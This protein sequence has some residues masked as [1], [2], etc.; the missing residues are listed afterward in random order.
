[1]LSRVFRVDEAREYRKAGPSD[2]VKLLPVKGMNPL[3]LP[4][5]LIE[6]LV[7]G[8]VKNEI[9]HLSGPTGSAKTSLIEALHVIPE[10]FLTICS[11]LGFP[12][13]PLHVYPIEM[14]TYD[15]PGELYQRRAIKN[16]TT[17]D[18]Q[19]GLVQALLKATQSDQ[20]AYHL[21]WLREIGR[22]HSANVQ[23]GLFNLVTKGDILLPDGSRIDGRNLSWITD[24]NYQAETNAVHTLV[25]FDDGLKRRFPINLTLDY[26]S[27][28]QEVQVIQ[29]LVA[30]G[31]FD[32][33]DEA[34]VLKVVRLGHV[35]RNHRSEGNLQSVPPPTIYG[36]LS[37][38]RMA[39]SL[40]H[41]SLQQIAMSTLLGNASPDDLKH[42]C[43]VFNE[44]FGF[45]AGQ[46]EDPTKGKGLF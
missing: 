24:S 44:V 6:I 46:E 31:P 12:E 14:A 33:I 19:S 29:H 8:I 27:A 25:I 34:L 36:Y 18:E 38:L 22:V 2:L 37:F 17:Y 13:L 7:Y 1:M 43:S 10:N 21:I 41:L 32:K 3:F 16:G 5:S 20:K 9:I 30:E 15:A 45:Q 4:K 28:E 40:P 23:G 39:Q 11:S 26:L 42:V 35:I